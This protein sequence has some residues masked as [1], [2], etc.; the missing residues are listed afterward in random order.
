[1]SFPALLTTVRDLFLKEARV[2]LAKFNG[3]EQRFSPDLTLLNDQPIENFFSLESGMMAHARFLLE[4]AVEDD[5]NAEDNKKNLAEFFD[6]I[7]QTLQVFF[8]LSP[9]GQLTCLPVL[10]L[11]FFRT[12]IIDGNYF[13][14]F[15]F[16][17]SAVGFVAH[18]L[19][20][21]F[22]RFFCR[23]GFAFSARWNYTVGLFL[24]FFSSSRFFLIFGLDHDL[25]TRL[26]FGPS[27]RNCS[28]TDYW[29]WIILW[30]SFFSRCA[31]VLSWPLSFFRTMALHACVWALII[32]CSTFVVFVW[33]CSW[34]GYVQ[35]FSISGS[36]AFFRA[37]FCSFFRSDLVGGLVAVFFW[38]EFT[39]PSLF[40][41]ARF[42]LWPGLPLGVEASW[43]VLYQFTN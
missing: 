22:E 42:W 13:H 43:L 30:L 19:R 40:L 36:E 11:Q 21:G 37:D 25:G 1:M 12:K 38:S 3:N 2:F 31:S 27:G 16:R 32:H 26:T 33:G 34:S 17:F 20:V 29:W 6:E 4:Q 8:F 23:L 28:T 39:R 7:F 10:R 14:V 9:G 18:P 24:R 35:V 5:Q 15:R 41:M